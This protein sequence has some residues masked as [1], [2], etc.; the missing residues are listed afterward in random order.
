MDGAFREVPL[1]S[2]AKAL[3]GMHFEGPAVVAQDDTTTVVLP[4]YR[5]TVDEYSNLR[6][7]R[8]A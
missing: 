3:P 4:R 6:I 2:R 8:G 7:S 5:C 1:Y